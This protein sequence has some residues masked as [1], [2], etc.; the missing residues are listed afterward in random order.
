V[1][2]LPKVDGGERLQ[3]LLLTA[4]ALV[5][6]TYSMVYVRDVP[7]QTVVGIVAIGSLFALASH[8]GPNLKPGLEPLVGFAV[9]VLGFAV[10]AIVAASTSRAHSLIAA[11]IGSL[12]AQGAWALRRY[13]FNPTNAGRRFLS[14]RPAKR[15]IIGS[16]AGIGVAV[17]LSL[18]ALLILAIAAVTGDVSVA[19]YRDYGIVVVSYLGAGILGGVAVGLLAPLVQWPLGAIL[20]GIPLTAAIY[21]TIAVAARHL[22][23]LNDGLQPGQI[24]FGFGLLVLLYIGPMW[25]LV[26]KQWIERSDRRPGSADHFG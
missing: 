2:E 12:V 24:P 26:A 16:L 18:Y 7:W 5:Y 17:L 4:G 14:E 11:G 13:P 22:Q 6:V 25:G 20:L 23:T 21:G 3:F 15:A 8:L 1:A 9:A 19:F 10:P